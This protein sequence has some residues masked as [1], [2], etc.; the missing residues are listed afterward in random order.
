MPK[1][2]TFFPKL[3]LKYAINKIKMASRPPK[4]NKNTAINPLPFKTVKILI[5]Q[6]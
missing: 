1:K 4:T 3:N 5:A 6:L 2:A